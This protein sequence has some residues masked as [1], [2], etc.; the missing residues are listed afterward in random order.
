MTTKEK[1]DIKRQEIKDKLNKISLP[2]GT[3]T[4]ICW[5]IGQELGITGTTVL[6]Y[7]GGNIKDGY[8]AEAILEEF[9]IR[10]LISK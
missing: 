1:L 5:E 4:N 7:I 3:A 8:L 6:Y 2:N 10:K 9:K